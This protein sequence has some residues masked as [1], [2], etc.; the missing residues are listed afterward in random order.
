MKSLLCSVDWFLRNWRP[1]VVPAKVECVLVSVK[2]GLLGFVL[3][4]STRE[5]KG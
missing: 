4:P 2:T 1:V 3:A 5:E